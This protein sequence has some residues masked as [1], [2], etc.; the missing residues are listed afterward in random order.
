MAATARGRGIAAGAAVAALLAG[1][2]Q[3]AGDASPAGSET[4]PAAA[5]DDPR[6][7]PRTDFPATLAELSRLGGMTA[8]EW[9]EDP[10]LADA[11]VELAPDGAWASA[12]LTYLAADADRFLTLRM[13]PGS[14]SQQRPT[15]GGLGLT[16]VGGEALEAVPPL[17]DDTL[18]PADLAA[19]AA[20]VLERCGASG[21]VTTVLYAT[22]A[23]AIWDGQSWT[24]DP[25]WRATVATGSGGAAVDPR[26]GA[27]VLDDPC[28][29]PLP[30]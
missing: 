17:P 7:R 13:E 18:E 30:E 2:C 5:P 23:P 29:E 20:P 8:A 14:T 9:Q 28:L 25:Q 6:G 10:R 11:A 4:V 26:T 24:V 19:A 16:A 15:L 12:R 21:A 27:A 22:G 1:G 3:P